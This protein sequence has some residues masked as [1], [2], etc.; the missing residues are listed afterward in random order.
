MNQKEQI[1][2]KEQRV[3]TLDLVGCVVSPA[4]IELCHCSVKSTIDKSKRL[5]V[6]VF[7]Y[8]F[9]HTDIGISCHF[10]SQNIIVIL[11]FLKC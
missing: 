7:Q 3:N 9:P 2:V 5:S 6:A 11:I 4:T 1:P 10:T 8:I